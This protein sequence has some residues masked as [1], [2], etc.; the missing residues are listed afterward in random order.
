MNTPQSARDPASGER[1]MLCSAG[2]LVEA[3]GDVRRLGTALV[4]A[5]T[6][7]TRRLSVNSLRHRGAEP[8]VTQRNG[9]EDVLRYH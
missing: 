1:F 3:D 9:S 8:A 2:Q 5:P 4:A 6:A 7:G